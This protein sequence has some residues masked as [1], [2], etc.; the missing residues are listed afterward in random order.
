M[1]LGALWLA[2]CG[3]SGVGEEAS[4]RDW[5]EPSPALWEATGPE[6]ETAYL[7]GTIHSLPDR[8]DWR[9]P[10]L[11]DSIET[12]DILLVEIANLG[13]SDAA[14]REFLARAYD[15]RLP[16]I[17]E[18]VPESDR[19]ELSLALDLA[20]LDPDSLIH[21]ENWAAALQLGNAKRCNS[22]QN[23]VDRALLD[24]VPD[25]R[26]LESFAEQF[27]IFDAL[28]DAA[29][30]D[31]LMSVANERGCSA[32]EERVAAWLTGDLA[33]LGA[34][35]ARGFRGN[36]NLQIRLLDQRNAGYVADIVALH[37]AQPNAE[38]MVAVGAGHM[39]GST[40]VPALLAAEGYEVRRIQ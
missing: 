27:A 22:S 39:L 34:S 14:E 24:A 10:A 19:E 35:I 37:A 17:L 32:G 5:P 29:Q 31:L 20:D 7:F 26:S 8:V 18:R 16:P 12:S 33:E 40:G 1:T 3:A 4:Q 30:V 38:L 2:S 28:P 9:T 23:G 21:T 11:T 25:V 13:D 6:G 15:L 36:A